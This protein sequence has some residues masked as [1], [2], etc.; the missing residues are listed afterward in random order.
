MVVN[1]KPSGTSKSMPAGIALGWIAEMLMAA[2]MCALLAILILDEKMDWGAIGYG[3]MVI[4]FASSYL[5]AKIA[6]NLIARRKLVVCALS[7][8]VYIATLLAINILFFDG[9]IGAVWAPA[10]L[11][12]GGAAAAAVMHQTQKGER[13][14]RKRKRR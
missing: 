4:L 5:G 1:Q 6:C 9:K 10:L 11:V 7:G 12:F 3:V 8:G 2:A 14:R 13:R